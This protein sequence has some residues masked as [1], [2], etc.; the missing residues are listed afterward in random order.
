MV[1]TILNSFI[2]EP[3]GRKKSFIFGQLIILSGWVM[4]Y[5]ACSFQILL[6][7]R[8]VMGIGVG[9]VFPVTC[10]YLSEI[11]LVSSMKIAYLQFKNFFSFQGTFSWNNGCNE[12]SDYLWC[13]CVFASFWSNFRPQRVNN[14][15]VFASYLVS[16]VFIFPTRITFMATEKVSNI[17]K[18]KS[19][20]SFFA[21]LGISQMML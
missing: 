7:A 8:L 18:T 12:Y 11:A 1:S 20:F 10:I 13:F 14:N 5:F 2:T 21:L 3:L 19:Q 9:I 17:S 4:L 16:R 6:A 15:I